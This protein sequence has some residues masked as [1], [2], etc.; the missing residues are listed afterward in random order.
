MLQVACKNPD[1]C[2][3]LGEYD[4][5]IKSFLMTLEILIILTE[6]L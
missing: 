3:A 2:L 5:G 4:V 1:N 6:K